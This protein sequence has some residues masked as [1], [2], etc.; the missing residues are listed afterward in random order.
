GIFE[1]DGKLDEQRA[2]ASLVGYGVEAFTGADFV[3]VGGADGRGGSGLHHGDRRV[4]EGAVELRGEKKARSHRRHVAAPEL[5]ELR[6]QRSIKRSIN[7]DRVEKAR[8]IFEL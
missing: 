8:E 2:Q 4:R 6:R 3:L 5:G 7:F 1:R